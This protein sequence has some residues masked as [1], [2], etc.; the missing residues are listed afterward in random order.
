MTYVKKIENRADRLMRRLCEIRMDEKG[1]FSLLRRGMHAN[2]VT[3]AA[4]VLGGMGIDV[5][6]FEARIVAALF[7][8]HRMHEPGK[9]SFGETCR[10]IALADSADKSVAASFDRRFR[11]LLDSSSAEDLARHLRS[12]ITFADQKKIGVNYADLF[13]DLAMW[14]FAAEDR[15]LRWASD[16]WPSRWDEEEPAGEEAAA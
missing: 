8:E 11:R 10:C 3:R 9:K 15:R 7:A 16:F 2:Q 5:T 13:K 14:S 12:W 4:P 6:N 1:K